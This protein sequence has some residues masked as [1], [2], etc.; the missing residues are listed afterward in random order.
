[1]TPTSYVYR[2]GTQTVPFLVGPRVLNRPHSIPTDAEI[3]EMRAVMAR[4]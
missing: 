3:D 2:P 1:M 4:Q